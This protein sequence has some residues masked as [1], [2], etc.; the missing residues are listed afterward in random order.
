MHHHAVR[1]CIIGEKKCLCGET[2]CMSLS[3]EKTGCNLVLGHSGPCRNTAFPES[4]TWKKEIDPNH[5]HFADSL[6]PPVLCGHCGVELYASSDGW[7]E[8][9]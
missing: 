7:A 1:A 4:G 8:K 5:R 9:K 3:P 6:T 2:I